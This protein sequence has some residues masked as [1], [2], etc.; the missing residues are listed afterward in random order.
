MTDSP[1]EAYLKEHSLEA[2]IEEAVKSLS[3][4]PKNPYAALA[5]HFAAGKPIPAPAA[6]VR[7]GRARGRGQELA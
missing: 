1:A 3:S 6:K 4:M 7:D 2:K 5:E